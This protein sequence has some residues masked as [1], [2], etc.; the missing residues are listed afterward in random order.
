MGVKYGNNFATRQIYHAIFFISVLNSK[1]IKSLFFH[2]ILNNYY[3]FSPPKWKYI[4]YQCII[5]DE[6]TDQIFN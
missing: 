6:L 3:H 2:S 5:V 1:Q 4:G